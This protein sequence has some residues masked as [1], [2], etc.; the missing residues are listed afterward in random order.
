MAYTFT[1]PGPLWLLYG[2]IRDCC[3]PWT[4]QHYL[5]VED[6]INEGSWKTG[7]ICFEQSLQ[8]CGNSFVLFIERRER[9]SWTSVVLKTPILTLNNMHTWKPR[10]NKNFRNW[11]FQLSAI[12]L[13]TAS[14][15]E[16]K[17]I[18]VNVTMQRQST[19]VET[20]D[21]SASSNLTKD[22][23]STNKKGNIHCYGCSILR[24]KN[25][26][27]NRR[28][29]KQRKNSTWEHEKEQN[30][31]LAMVKLCMFWTT[32]IFLS[33][34]DRPRIVRAITW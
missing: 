24:Q 6:F 5:R 29:E 32:N 9:S 8:N 31:R 25:R 10:T 34:I 22:R 12:L 19:D 3:T 1:G 18:K 2:D 17:Y 16:Q 4:L 26:S 20:L 11:S 28:I 27:S 13:Q 33:K 15:Q 7:G 14:I 23:N 30:R 21:K